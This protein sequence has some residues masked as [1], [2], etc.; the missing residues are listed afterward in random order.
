MKKSVFWSFVVLS[1]LL[2]L[3]L[4]SSSDSFAQESPTIFTGFV[5][6][7]GAP[8]PEETVIVIMLDDGKLL[9]VAFTGLGNLDSNQYRL[10]V[11]YSPDLENR[12]VLILFRD[13]RISQIEPIAVI[14]KANATIEAD[15]A[16]ISVGQVLTPT[17]TMTPI[18]TIIPTVTPSAT[19]TAIP[20]AT[21][22]TSDQESV[23]VFT[24]HV[25]IDGL[26]APER[27]FV[28]IVLEDGRLLDVG[29]T[30]K[31]NLDPDQYAIFVDASPEFENGVVFISLVELPST[32][33]TAT[34]RAGVVVVV[35]IIGSSVSTALP[36]IVPSRTTVLPSTPRPVETQT[37]RPVETQTPTATPSPT[38]TALVTESN[39]NAGPLD[40]NESGGSGLNGTV[41]WIIIGVVLIFLPIGIWST[42]RML[43]S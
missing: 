2:I 30:G 8:A 9:D 36:A 29:F 34:F 6:I 10:E 39:P 20:T 37:P 41:V 19:P 32:P 3:G 21:P 15:L 7:D 33:E 24:G 16:G 40:S 5:T 26:P 38:A 18:P 28:K 25:S 27:T 35:D 13:R 1:V 42:V 11:E 12:T 4:F 43:R 23:V 17:P 31:G 22:S 14:F